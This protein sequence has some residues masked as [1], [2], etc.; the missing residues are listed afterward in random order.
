MHLPPDLIFSFL[1]HVARTKL[2]LA[3]H[4]GLSLRELIV[5]ATIATQGPLSFKQLHELLAIPKSGL[6]GLID[7]L[8]EK[9]L[10][11][12]RQDSQDRRRWFVALTGPGQRLVQTIQDED[13]R[14]V[15]SALDSLQESEQTAF[16]KAAEA[17]H[18]ELTRATVR[19]SPSTRDRGRRRAQV[20]TGARRARMRLTADKE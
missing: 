5:L 10:V 16:L 4:H 11:N 17:V 20:R 15:E 6:T 8:H 12:R 18:R 2:S 7:Y 1:T 9:R 13:T 3:Q 14:L 19:A